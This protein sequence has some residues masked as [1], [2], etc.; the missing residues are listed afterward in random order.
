MENAAAA[1]AD[2]PSVTATVPRMAKRTKRSARIASVALLST[3]VF[4]NPPPKLEKAPPDII[5]NQPNPAYDRQPVDAGS[6]LVAEPPPER[7]VIINRV[8]VPVAELKADA[9][10]REL[11]K[12]K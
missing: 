1:R 4:A 12:K 10:V 9:G 7:P 11:K 6:P 5:V 8:P 2:L 3:S